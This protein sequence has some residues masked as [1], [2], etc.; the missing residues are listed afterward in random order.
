VGTEFEEVSSDEDRSVYKLGGGEARIEIDTDDGNI[1]LR[2][3]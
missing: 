2:I 3:I 1:E